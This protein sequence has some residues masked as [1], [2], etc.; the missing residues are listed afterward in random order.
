MMCK[1]RQTDSDDARRKH[2][3]GPSRILHRRI[4]I[5]IVTGRKSVALPHASGRLLQRTLD[6]QLRL[7]ELVRR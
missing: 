2:E 4:Y 6:A 5:Y 7:A 1:N 3:C